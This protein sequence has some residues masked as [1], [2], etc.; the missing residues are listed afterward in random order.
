MLAPHY[1][2]GGWYLQIPIELNLACK[3]LHWCVCVRV[4]IFL[5]ESFR[6]TPP[7]IPRVFES[8]WN[9]FNTFLSSL[10][11]PAQLEPVDTTT[12]LDLQWRSQCPMLLTVTLNL[13]C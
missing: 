12:F 5:K 11:A 7:I 2:L 6:E 10:P 3:L 13:R 9:L 8:P 1:D 4:N